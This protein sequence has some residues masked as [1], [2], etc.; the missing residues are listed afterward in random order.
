MKW[1]HG[2]A[3]WARR[4]R[5][6]TTRGLLAAVGNRTPG[7]GRCASPR[8][9]RRAR[10]AL[11]RRTSPTATSSCCACRRTPTCWQNVTA[12]ADVLEPGSVVVDHS[13]VAVD[14]ARRGA[15]D[16][17]RA[18][19]RFPR[20]AGVR[21]RRRRAQ[22]QAVGH[23]RRRRRRP[24][25]RAAGA[26]E[27]MRAH[28]PHGRHGRRPGHQGG[29]P[30]AGRRHRRR[31]CAKAWRWAK[32][33]AWI[34]RRLLPTLAAGA[35]GNWFLD[36]RGATMLRD[37]F[38]PGLQVRRSCTRTCASCSA[39]ARGSRHPH[40]GDRAVAGRLRRADRARHGR[41]G[42]FGADHAQA[43]LSRS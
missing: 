21:R 7:Q 10:R 13:T 20:R 36:K 43:R 3:R 37:E 40:D 22:R 17:G 19:H 14:T 8:E 26:R 39:I 11:A 30:G 1:F 5:T 32:S 12:L 23:G 6:C 42:H 41:R 24:R 38:T 18:R 29:E 25:A 4:W 34:R 31:P 27:P 28:H 16:A 9:L 2:L 15:R 35:A 33:S